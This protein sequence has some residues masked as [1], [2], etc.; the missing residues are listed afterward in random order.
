MGNVDFTHHELAITRR[1]MQRDRRLPVR[2]ARDLI[3]QLL[4]LRLP[5]GSEL[6][7]EESKELARQPNH[8]GVT[9]HRRN[10]LL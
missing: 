8:V 2:G 10:L 6:A 5:R 4:Q 3:E 7:N 1:H 9:H